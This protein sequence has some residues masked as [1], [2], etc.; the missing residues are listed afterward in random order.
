[1]FHAFVPAPTPT[2]THKGDSELTHS[3]DT[4]ETKSV[5]DFFVQRGEKKKESYSSREKQCVR[6]QHTKDNK[7]IT[8]CQ[9]K[10]D[11]TNGYA[12]EAESIHLFKLHISASLLFI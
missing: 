1:M 6:L 9:I 3:V 7:G 2:L 5:F 10:K 4:S 8:L 11:Y 12:V